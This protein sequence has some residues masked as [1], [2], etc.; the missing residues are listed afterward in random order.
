MAHSELLVIGAT[1]VGLGLIASRENADAQVL[2]IDRGIIPGAEFVNALVPGDGW[3]AAP[4][5]SFAKSVYDELIARNILSNGRIHLPAISPVLYERMKPLASRIRLST[6]ILGIAATASGY[7]MTI[8]DAGGISKITAASIIDTTTARISRPGMTFASK[9]FNV[10][11]DAPA[12]DFSEII[13]QH[14]T[15]TVLPCR[16]DSERI[17]SLPLAAND[18]FA[19]ARRKLAQ[20]WKE[21]DEAL[22]PWSLAASAGAFAYTVTD[23]RTEIAPS[24]L[25]LPSAAYRNIT[26]AIEAGENAK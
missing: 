15:A 14:G 9:A 2:L 13:G 7:E 19:D 20:F 22:R 12:R 18:G 4:S 25:H 11:L 26:L 8:S 17:L 5:S 10:L 23:K 24:W 16:F 21:R 6:E 1:G 3:D